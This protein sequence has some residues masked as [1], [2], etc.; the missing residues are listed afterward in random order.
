LIP[1]KDHGRNVTMGIGRTGV[2]NR[3]LLVELDIMYIIGGE[4]GSQTPRTSHDP[5][6]EVAITQIEKHSRA[7]IVLFPSQRW[8]RTQ[9]LSDGAIRAFCSYLPVRARL[10]MD[11]V[12]REALQRRAEPDRL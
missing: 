9:S 3:L 5:D 6:D 10:Q 8:V 1:E 11:P 4:H 12:P 7:W 2:A